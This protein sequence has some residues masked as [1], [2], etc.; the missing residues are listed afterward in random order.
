MTRKSKPGV[1]DAVVGR[2]PVD[3]ETDA[4]SNIGI[5]HCPDF[6]QIPLEHHSYRAACG[7]LV[8]GFDCLQATVGCKP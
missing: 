8:H 1:V 7:F 5:E 6:F 4:E 2:N 3:P